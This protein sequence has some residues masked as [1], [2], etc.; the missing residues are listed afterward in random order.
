MEVGTVNGSCR[1]RCV[2]YLALRLMLVGSM[3]MTFREDEFH[4]AVVG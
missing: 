1:T 2:K 3:V 4:K